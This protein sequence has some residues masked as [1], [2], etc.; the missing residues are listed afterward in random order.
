MWQT[1]GVLNRVINTVYNCLTV[2]G[3]WMTSQNI[4][5]ALRLVSIL[6]L[7]LYNTKAS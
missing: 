1:N 3:I 7:T 6:L 4:T 2:S 5:Q